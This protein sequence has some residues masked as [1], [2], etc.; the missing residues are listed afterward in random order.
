M[1]S[2]WQLIHRNCILKP[3]K[4]ENTSDLIFFYF[5][6]HRE[7]SLVIATAFQA[8][9]FLDAVLVWWSSFFLGGTAPTHFPHIFKCYLIQ[10]PVY[11]IYKGSIFLLLYNIFPQLRW[12]LSRCLRNAWSMFLLFWYLNFKW[13]VHKYTTP[14]YSNPLF[15]NNLFLS[16]PD[17]LCWDVT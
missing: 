14:S 9:I 13:S 16:T 17:W 7:L 10:W 2:F 11:S 4:W 1:T 3:L 15:I 12:G 5:L 8:N 6:W